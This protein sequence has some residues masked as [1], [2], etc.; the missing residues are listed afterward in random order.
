[1][2]MPVKTDAD[3]KLI[4]DVFRARVARAR[5]GECRSDSES[6]ARAWASFCGA[7]AIFMAAIVSIVAALND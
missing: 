4:N 5:A 3:L 7:T 6:H 2:A 1:V